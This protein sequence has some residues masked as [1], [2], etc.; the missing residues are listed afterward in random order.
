MD[1]EA[2][3][4][5]ITKLKEDI[6][7]IKYQINSIFQDIQKDKKQSYI[8]KRID[9]LIDNYKNRYEKYQVISGLDKEEIVKMQGVLMNIGEKVELV[10]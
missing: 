2:L 3:N 6:R 10:C 8:E 7:N 9:R 5:Y 1:N 4:R